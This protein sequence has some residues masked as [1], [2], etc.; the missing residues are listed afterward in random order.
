M[1]TCLMCGHRIPEHRGSL[2]EKK[3]DYFMQSSRGRY[4]PYWYK[5]RRYYGSLSQFI[6]DN[7]IRT[8]RGRLVSRVYFTSEIGRALKRIG[9]KGGAETL[10]S[11]K[12]LRYHKEA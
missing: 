3:F 12:V 6:S 2:D 5:W 11:L 4:K 10:K 7:N 1:K 8:S 9:I